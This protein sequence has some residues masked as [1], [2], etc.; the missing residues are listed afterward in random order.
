MRIIG[1]TA[2]ATGV[3]AMVGMGMACGRA[4]A[5]PSSLIPAT[6][7][8]GP[9]CVVSDYS[10][11]SDS[12]SK[13]PPTVSAHPVGVTVIW[14][15]GLNSKTCKAAMTRGNAH[16]ASALASDIDHASVVP[17]STTIVCPADD[18]TSARLYFTYSRGAMQRIDAD[19]SGCAWI[20]A[21]GDASRRSNAQFR[22][23]MATLAPSAWRG[24]VAPDPD[25]TG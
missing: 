16:I 14:L 22:K 13:T 20:T 25:P 3:V 15:P 7:L 19:L 8:S 5:A 6:H 4:A 18:G 9:V 10:P 23:N 21:P 17:N 12:S 24:Y 11:I 1:R 2:A